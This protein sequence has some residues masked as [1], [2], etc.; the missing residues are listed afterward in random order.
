[1]ASFAC[2]TDDDECDTS[3]SKNPDPGIINF[4][5]TSLHKAEQHVRKLQRELL[6]SQRKYDQS[7]EGVN[8][9]SLV[10]RCLNNYV[11]GAALNIEQLLSICDLSQ[12]TPGIIQQ[13]NASEALWMEELMNQEEEV[14]KGKA[15]TTEVS[16]SDRALTPGASR[17]VSD[18]A[19]TPG[20]SLPVSD[21]ALTP[22]ASLPD[23]KKPAYPP[24]SLELSNSSYKINNADQMSVSETQQSVDKM[25]TLEARMAGIDLVPQKKTTGT[26]KA[27]P[28]VD[29]TDLENDIL[30][31]FPFEIVPVPMNDVNKEKPR[32]YTT[33][34]FAEEVGQQIGIVEA[35]DVVDHKQLLF[36]MGFQDPRVSE[37]LN[38]YGNL[39]AAIQWLVSGED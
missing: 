21:K 22:G 10:E 15:L 36:E 17:S 34:V 30:K 18:K 25:V 33:N 39:P 11:N 3:R 12:S 28:K 31:Y 1:M 20:A 8:R 27:G 32:T 7:Q 2:V 9:L 5:E 23:P 38:T 19:L 35:G 16:L 4:Y 24:F 29:D 26:K 37:A 14:S 6:I 13:L